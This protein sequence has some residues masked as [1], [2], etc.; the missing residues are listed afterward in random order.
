MSEIQ[1]IAHFDIP[2]AQ[3]DA[4]KAAAAKCMQSVREKDGGTLQY[5]WHLNADM[6][7]CTV[8]ERYRDSA[9]VIEHVVNLGELLG[10]ISAIGNLTIDIY[11]TPSEELV[12]ATAGIDYALH[13]PFQSI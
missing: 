4:F 3:L 13:S 5:D 10:E 6:S 8:I 1:V 11:G 9:A 7:G 12:A 2:E